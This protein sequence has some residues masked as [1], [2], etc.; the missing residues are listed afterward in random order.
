M[1]IAVG[2][3]AVGILLAVAEFVKASFAELI[4]AAATLVRAAAA[5]NVGRLAAI[6][7]VAVLDGK[8]TS[9]FP[10]KSIQKLFAS[11]RVA[12]RAR[13]S[14]RVR[15]EVGRVIWMART[16]GRSSFVSR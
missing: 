15:Y 8:A 9:G 2:V 6:K 11:L 13:P 16:R 14:T 1:P 4:A 5:P 7:I 12:R 3:A 10:D